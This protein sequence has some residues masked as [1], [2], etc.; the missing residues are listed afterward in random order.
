MKTVYINQDKTFTYSSI[1]MEELGKEEVLL[2]I[3]TVGLCGSDLN[4]YKGLNPM[5]GYPRVL[6]HESSGEIVK[7]GSDVPSHIKIG[8][9][10][11]IYP[12][13][14]CNNCT[15]CQQKRFNCC[16]N[17]QTL[18]VQQDGTMREYYSIH[19]S[20]LFQFENLNAQELALIEPLAVGYHSVSRGRCK[21]N[22]FVT[23]IGCGMIGI[24]AVLAAVLE[25]S[26]V[27]VIDI[28]ENKLKLIKSFG[29]E[30]TI[31]S[32][33]K[34]PITEINN[35]TNG[36]GTDVVIEA[37]GTPATYRLAIDIVSFAGRVIYIGYAKTSVEFE[38][39]N[40][41]VKELDILG[42]RNATAHDFNMVGNYL[43]EKRFDITSLITQKY[44]FDEL[45]TALVFWNSNPD[46]VIKILIM[47]D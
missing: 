34:D 11:S 22:E 46:K 6:G 21:K 27:I 35:I 1:N 13:D 40:F 3:N 28:D 2:K 33:E 14:N 26:R 10:A 39:K 32:L 44:S 20:K 36:H 25:G 45:E 23:I 8:S 43:S 31:N 29:V 24:G 12:Y 5:V 19:Y 9:L 7:I 18:G 16:K 42:S 41:V 15:S 47:M 38:T 30:F 37:V 17:N 4:T